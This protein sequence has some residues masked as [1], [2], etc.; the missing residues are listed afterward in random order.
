MMK[1]EL[2]EPKG[3]YIQWFLCVLYHAATKPNFVNVQ[4]AKKKKK[5]LKALEYLLALVKNRKTQ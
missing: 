5:H 2:K 3:D 1:V 4:T